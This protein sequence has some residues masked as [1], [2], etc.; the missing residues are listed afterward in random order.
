MTRR[1]PLLLVLALLLGASLAWPARAG[2][3]TPGATDATVDAGAS[4]QETWFGITYTFQPATPELVNGT[5]YDLVVTNVTPDANGTSAVRLLRPDD[6]CQTNPCQTRPSTSD[7]A[8]VG[9]LNVTFPGF[10]FDAAGPWTLRDDANGTVA[11]LLVTPEKAGLTV[12]LS[13]SEVQTSNGSATFTITVSPIGQGQIVGLAG[14]CLASGTTA[15]RTVQGV[16]TYTYTGG[17]PPAGSQPYGASIQTYDSPNDPEHMPEVYNNATLLVDGPGGNCTAPG[18]GGGG[19]QTPPAPNG[20]TVSVSAPAAGATVAGAFLAEGNASDDDGTVRLVQVRVDGGAWQDASGT[21]SWGVSLDASGLANGAHQLDARAS[22]DNGTS[23]L[24]SVW[25]VVD[26]APP[27]VAIASPAEGATVGGP[28]TVRGTASDANGQDKL[29]EVDVS[30][31]EGATWTAA[32]GTAYWRF[33][34]DTTTLPN[35][36]LAVLAR[37]QDATQSSALAVVNLT[38]DNR[39]PDLAVTSVSVEHGRLRIA[40]AVDVD[41]DPLALR[42]IDVGVANLGGQPAAAS[43]LHVWLTMSSRATGNGTDDLGIV[44]V[45]RLA[46]GAST[47]ISVPWDAT[48]E[49]GDVTVHARVLPAGPDADPTNDERDV[50]DYVLVSGLGGSTVP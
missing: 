25:F 12:S 39:P 2:Q 32:S 29:R 30:L 1:A 48:R 45:P 36:P 6:S 23:P 17:A 16:A 21:T 13:P 40:G 5:Q 46:A 47:T 33:D 7:F 43:P 26:N 27:T 9:M 8:H 28:I 35:G 22:D 41:G 42:T 24:G 14:A 3:F 4:T 15:T 44:D 20:P 34:L 19:N 18:G 31:D 38:V 11:T 10:T 37:S 50:A 49:L